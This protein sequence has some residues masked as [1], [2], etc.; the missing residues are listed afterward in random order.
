MKVAAVVAWTILKDYNLLLDVMKTLLLKRRVLTT[1]SLIAG[2]GAKVMVEEILMPAA[3]ASSVVL[4]VELMAWG[5]VV[6]K[7][8]A[9]PPNEANPA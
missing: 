3:L 6:L 9:V 2:G 7:Q 5:T 4:L 8:T 1:V